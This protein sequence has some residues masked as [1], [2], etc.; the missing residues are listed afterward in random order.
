MPVRDE[1]G[2]VVFIAAE[3]RDI[4]EKKAAQA[5]FIEHTPAVSLS[6]CRIAPITFP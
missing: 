3:G 6:K 2:T 1:H 4:T 5:D